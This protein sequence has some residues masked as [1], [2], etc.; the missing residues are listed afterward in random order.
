MEPRQI[1][2]RGNERMITVDLESDLLQSRII[3]ITGVI[4]E[5]TVSTYQAELIYLANQITG[6]KLKSP[7]KIY[8]NSPGGELYSTFGLYDV[9]QRLIE[10][11]YI[12]QT[13]V[14]GLAASAAAFILLSGSEGH[15]SATPHSRIMIHQP[16]SGTYGTVTDMKIDLEESL[17]VKQECIKI[18]N[19]HSK[20]DLSDLIERDK[21]LSPDN[22]K[23]LGLIDVVK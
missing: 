11:G 6:D 13:K 4:N 23:E 8:I 7:I 10:Q 16:S 2:K 18:I 9:M 12:I 22:A 5:E 20:H 19:K 14:M 21:W 1:I 3:F 17:A 15:R